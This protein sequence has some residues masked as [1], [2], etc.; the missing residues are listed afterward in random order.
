MP[1]R[2]PNGPDWLISPTGLLQSNSLVL[3]SITASYKA[4]HLC[5]EPR[6]ERCVIFDDHKRFA[7]LTEMHLRLRREFAERG[8]LVHFLNFK[9]EDTPEG[10]FVETV[11]AAQAQLER[12]QN[13]RQSRQK[14]KARLEKGYWTRKAPRGLKYIDAKGG[15]KILVH[16]EP[17]ASIV[18]DALQ[19]Y[20]SGRFSTVTEVKRFLERQPQYPKDKANGELHNQT[21][22]RLLRQKLYAGYLEL[23]AGVYRCARH[24]MNRSSVLPHFNAYRASL[25]SAFMH[26]CARISVK[27]F[28]CAVPSHVLVATTCSRLD[29]ARASSKNILIISA[30][31][32][33]VNL[34]ARPSHV[35]SLKGGL[36]ICSNNSLRHES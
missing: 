7:R 34:E 15:G 12:E 30:R 26:P 24:S 8:A 1:E 5:A 18:Q 17:I 16:D 28:R 25:I 9:T 36:F 27:T 19:G 10:R 21:V 6:H 22:P 33:D 29:G 23:Q 4:G 2:S 3:R 13:S 31:Q 11:F 20:A 14:T 32:A 35:I